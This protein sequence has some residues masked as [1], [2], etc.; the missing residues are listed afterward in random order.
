MTTDNHT[1]D[2]TPALLPPA[3]LA[4]VRDDADTC[5][6]A[7]ADGQIHNHT[8]DEAITDALHRLIAE[9]VPALLAHLDALQARAPDDGGEAD[10]RDLYLEIHG[11][12]LGHIWDSFNATTRSHMIRGALA[13]LA[14]GYA[15][16][17]AAGEAERADLAVT[18]DKVRSDRNQFRLLWEEDRDKAAR[19]TAELADVRAIEVNLR[20][21]C[22]ILGINIEERDAEVARL[23]AELDTWREVTGADT[24]HQLSAELAIARTKRRRGAG[25]P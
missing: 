9:H 13:M 17:V 11:S 14:R 18:I 21:S 24:P 23:T 8:G 6:E 15:R 5:C 19:L 2:P 16:G 7:L 20:E 25:R 4:A 12:T 1:P 3:R 22:R 10:G